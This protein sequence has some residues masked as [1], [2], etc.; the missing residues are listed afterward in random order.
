MEIIDIIHREYNNILENKKNIIQE[1]LVNDTIIE[2]F[3]FGFYKVDDRG[4]AIIK[5][6]VRVQSPIDGKVD[7]SLAKSSC[8]NVLVIKSEDEKYFLEYCGIPDVR[9]RNNTKVR[10]S[11]LIGKSSPGDNIEVTLYTTYGDRVRID[12][13]E[14]NNL[15]GG[16]IVFDKNKK[17]NYPYETKK[18]TP[19]S[20]T[21][22]PLISGMFQLPFKAL[23][24]PFKNKYDKSGNLTQKRWGS[25]VD[26]RP[27]DPWIL[28]AIKDPFGVKRRK[29][30]TE[31]SEENLKEEI[32]KIKKLIK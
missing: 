8:K 15:V 1:L 29:K 5:N 9:V 3:N 32:N 21:G 14:A 7:N 28:Q 11:D 19:K 4:R 30:E 25:P 23:S 16:E 13:R 24:Y 22:E 31:E 12:S 17:K 27:V 10:E 2:Q 6:T 26:K 20:T 18:E